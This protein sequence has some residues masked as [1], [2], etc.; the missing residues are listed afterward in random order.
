MVVSVLAATLDHL[1]VDADD[2]T[3]AGGM[4][5]FVGIASEV[6]FSGLSEV[7]EPVTG[8]A[9]VLADGE[10][11]V[12]LDV[13]DGHGIASVE[14]LNVGVEL[15]GN[16]VDLALDGRVD[17]GNLSVQGILG[18]VNSQVSGADELA[19]SDGLLNLED[20]AAVE[21]LGDGDD[22]GV[23]LIGVRIKLND[24][25]SPVG[26]VDGALSD[27]SS[28]DIPSRNASVEVVPSISNIGS[29]E[30]T[31]VD[32]I[33]AIAGRGKLDVIDGE[34]VAITG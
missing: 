32:K 21:A 25:S 33:G 28:H 15:S 11:L 16:H 23:P 14:V 7:L 3:E 4:G 20:E 18:I 22:L 31:I 17:G 12:G 29:G 19:T 9:A 34:T 5:T 8:S 24:L 1:S 30:I 2:G 6:K 13:L 10:V 26:I 27:F